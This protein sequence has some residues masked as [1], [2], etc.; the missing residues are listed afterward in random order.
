VTLALAIDLGSASAQP[1]EVLKKLWIAPIPAL[2][3][4]YFKYKMFG[5]LPD[6]LDI[7]LTP[8]RERWKCRVEF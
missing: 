7:G 8:F 4:N 1:V 5:E 2:A 3:P 6:G